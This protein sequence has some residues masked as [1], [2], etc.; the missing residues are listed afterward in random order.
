MSSP[1]FSAAIEAETFDIDDA[2]GSSAS[3]G[4]TVVRDAANPEPPRGGLDA[5]GLW[6]GYTGAGYLDMGADVGDAASFAVD[7]PTAGV[8][9]IAIRYANGASA[10][11]PMTL[12]VD[13]AATAALEGASTGAWS[14]WAEETVF[15]RLAPGPRVISLANDGRGGPNLDR[16]VVA[17]DA[18]LVIEAER[19]E[20]LSGFTVARNGV[21]SGGEMLQSSGASEQA[22]RT[23]YAG[24]A[25]LFD[26][27]LRHFD[28][29]D[30]V[31]RLA[32]LVNGVAVDAFLLDRDLGTDRPIAAALTARVVETVRLAPGDVI[33][34]RGFGRPGEPLRL[35]RLDITPSPSAPAGGPPSASFPASAIVPPDGSIAFTGASRPI[36]SDPDGDRLTVTLSAPVGA[37]ALRPTEV[38]TLVLD[39]GARAVVSGSAAG[40][41]AAL[42]GF[43]YTPPEGF[44]GDTAIRAV[45]TD[46]RF[47]TEAQVALSVI[48]DARIDLRSLDPGVFADRLH[49]NWIDE[50][51]ANSSTVR[52]AKTQATARIANEGATPLRL[53]GVEIDGPFRLAD[54]GAVSGRV[55]APGESLDV[56][57]LFDRAAFEQRP[58]AA[59]A[60]VNGTLRILSDAVDEPVAALAL[61]AAWQRKSEGGWEPNVNE[62]W[63]VLGFGNRIPGVPTR[64]GQPNPLDTFGLFAPFTQDEVLSP[65]W[66]IADGYAD[67]RITMIASFAGPNAQT[68][69]IHRP[70]SKGQAAASLSHLREDSQTILPRGVGSG[71]VGVS[72]E[73]GFA[74]LSFNREAIPDFWQG[75]D[76]FGIN[77]ANFSTDPSLNTTGKLPGEIAPGEVYGHWMRMF[78]ALDAK[79]NPIA[80]TFLGI[81]DKV[82]I[83]S[84]FNDVMFVITGI[85]P[86]SNAPVNIAPAMVSVEGGASRGFSGDARV[87]ISDPDG[88]LNR[89]FNVFLS[90]EH[91]VLTLVAQSGATVTGSGGAA[92]TVSGS[93]SAVNAT[94]ASLRY[95]APATFSGEDRLRIVANDRALSDVDDV[96]ITVTPSPA[97]LSLSGLDDA[98]ADQRLVFTN[99]NDSTTNNVFKGQSWRD[100]AQFEIANEGG[101]PLQI[102]SIG[103]ADPAAFR[104]VGAVPATVAPGGRATVT[105]AFVGEAP[106]TGPVRNA[107]FES[108][109]SIRTSAGAASFA[110]AGVAQRVSEGGGEPDPFTVIKAFGYA[111]G[112]GSTPGELAKLLPDQGD[113][114]PVET[115][116]AEVIAPYL[117]RDD[118]SRPIE[119]VQ[120]AAYLGS[121]GGV[122]DQATLSL[123]GL[124]SSLDRTALFTQSAGQFQ[125]VLPGAVGGGPTRAL[126]ERDGP[127]GIL[128]EV[129]DRDQYLAW[130]APVANATDPELRD[131]GGR[132][133]VD[134]EYRVDW[135]YPGPRPSAIEDGHFLRF[136]QALDADGEPIEGTLIGIQDYIGVRNFDFNDTIFLIRNVR[137]YGLGPQKDRDG[138][139]VLDLLRQDVDGDGLVSF[140]DPDDLPAPFRVEAESF[141][142][143]QGF[144]VASNGAASGRS[145]LAAGAPGEQ[146]ARHVFAGPAGVYDLGLGH[147]DENDGA[148]SLRVLV[149]GV[150]I[151]S[152]VWNRDLG[153]ASPDAQSRTER[154]IADVA[155]RPGD[156]IALRGFG[157]PGEPLRTDY[158]DFDFVAALPRPLPFR[159]EAES[160]ELVSGFRKA[161]NAA[162]SGGATI[163]SVGA[164]L[165]VA[166][167]GFEGPDGLYRLDLGYFD[168]NDGVASMRVFVNGVSID[169][170][171]WTSTAGSAGPDAAS[172]AVRRIENV[173]LE[174][175]DVIALRGFG[176]SSEP[177]RTDYLA[178]TWT[179]DLPA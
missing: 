125:T 107:L 81:Q 27:T 15:L 128:I 12:S 169:A 83:N 156:V 144:T 132:P 20:P 46:G 18:P 53:T 113:P 80:N 179:A 43:V 4:L 100:E 175:G 116:G 91:G 37:F 44:R 21:A 33:E 153:S 131:A 137:P 35:D 173:A 90:V 69:S 58:N 41:N 49:F 147:F 148:A 88:P 73:P 17:L 36:L 56:V 172:R 85:E 127:F 54:P 164:D 87:R 151:D 95:A 19:F 111:L 110:L 143:Q 99:I 98:A 48:G 109:L 9:A 61:S 165:Q 63:E 159:I 39:G 163:A 47:E 78:Q 24:P 25:G 135:N 152:F 92:A 68:I 79:G 71:G 168:E 101:T 117:I 149:N 42:T 23:V 5:A 174:T 122:G 114:A 103:I 2:T 123:H 60:V 157:A 59:S 119:V 65:Y 74:S 162:A 38:A 158:L 26:L 102:L 177:L 16:A 30:G 178:F 167:Y 76:V 29:N 45:T 140:F 112:A 7:A 67:A 118:A 84:D 13:G 115:I 31:A 126:V 3:T 145:L 28:E 139:G 130:S 34:L 138:D 105:V 70:F 22:A 176:V 124:G 97:R 104:I 10:A 57:A 52:A 142:I 170:W 120:L 106:E 77:A 150:E 161:A 62:V 154:A 1:L 75:D 160:F 146:I 64:D 166:R 50:P 171:D 40:V 8:Y 108:A 51:G 134:S 55:L 66:R 86:V 89:S 32:I 133:L 121:R 155:L 93:L 129:A 141:D 14:A 11:R 72:V 6:G 94:L 96:A 136:F 82:G